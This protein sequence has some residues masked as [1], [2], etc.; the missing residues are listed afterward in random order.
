MTTSLFNNWRDLLITLDWHTENQDADIRTA[1]RLRLPKIIDD[2]APTFLASLN[3]TLP[4][5]WSKSDNVEQQQAAKHDDA[6]VD[7]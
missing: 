4:N 2:D 5:L 3:K 6:E 7:H 1:K